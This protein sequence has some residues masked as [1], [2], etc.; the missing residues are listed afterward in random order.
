[1][2][3]AARVLVD[4]LLVN[5]DTGPYSER[6]VEALK[7][8]DVLY[9]KERQTPE[10]ADKEV[11]KG[12][13]VAA[14]LIP[15]DLSKKIEAHKPSQIQVIVDPVKQEGA[16]I[17]TGILNQVAGE[18][19]IWGEVSFGVKSML[20]QSPEF[21]QAPPQVQQAAALQTL[22]VIMTQLDEARRSP[23]I[24]VSSEDLA[25]VPARPPFNPAAFNNP[26]MLTMFAFF[27]LGMMASSILSEKEN[28]S[29][30]RLLASPIHPAAILAGKIL[31]YMTLVVLQALV[32][33][34]VGVLLFDMSLGRS[35]PAVL[36]ITLGIGFTASALG[37]LLA[38]L[39]RSAKQ[40][41]S[42][43]VV[44]SLLLGGLGGCIAMGSIFF[45]AKG[46]IMYY[47]SNLTPHAHTLEGYLRLFADDAGFMDA[48]P[49]IGILFG[50]GIVYFVIALVRFKFE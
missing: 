34:G 50:M 47:L 40:A 20:S 48:L 18:I 35:L 21:L 17:V 14:I 3:P 11:A 4:V 46:T 12:D 43:G 22:G 41:D 5:Q 27:L 44:I 13:A 32:I 23:A 33:L 1:M 31:A 39:A 16:S 9:V 25:G 45:R 15:A 49:Q 6:L 38:T 8:I 42:L 37:V 19:T 26:S 28:G 2:K 24:A 30:R 36:L 29:F 10:E 7:K